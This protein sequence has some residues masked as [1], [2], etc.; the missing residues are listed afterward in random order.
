V[1]ADLDDLSDHAIY[2]CGSPTMIADAK[3]AF[4]SRGA[5]VDYIYADSFVFQSA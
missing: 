5:S 2:L 4:A 1:L 3:I